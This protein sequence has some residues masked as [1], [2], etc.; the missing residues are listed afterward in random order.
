VR[1]S[2]NVVPP[3]ATRHIEGTFDLEFSNRVVC[4]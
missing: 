2:N 4:P 3:V 1:R